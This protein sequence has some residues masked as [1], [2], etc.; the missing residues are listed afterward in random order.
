M[1]SPADI[2]EATGVPFDEQGLLDMAETL[3][4]AIQLTIGAASVL[5]A[6]DR[7][8]DTEH[9]WQ[10]GADLERWIRENPDRVPT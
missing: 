7:V 4:E 9:A 1:K 5:M 8:M 6:G 10:L 2:E 3:T